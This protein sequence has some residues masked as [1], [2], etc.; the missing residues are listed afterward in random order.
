MRWKRMMGMTEEAVC[1]KCHGTFSGDDYDWDEDMCLHCL[2]PETAKTQP[3]P[4]DHSYGDKRNRTK[5][6]QVLDDL[7]FIP[8][9]QS[10]QAT[11]SKL[12]HDYG[13]KKRKTYK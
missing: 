5:A 6:G 11:K 13:V 4:I 12:E 2:Y 9:K 8:E 10:K 1:P 7:Q 3:V